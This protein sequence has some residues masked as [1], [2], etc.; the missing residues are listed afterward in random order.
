MST[1]ARQLL[2]AIARPLPRLLDLLGPSIDLARQRRCLAE[3]DGR[4]LK[5][6]GVSREQALA[7][8]EKPFWR[9]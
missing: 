4:L 2:P 8:S 6:I 9:R 1:N 5:D 3:L 7:E